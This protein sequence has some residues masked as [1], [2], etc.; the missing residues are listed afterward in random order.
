MSQKSKKSKIHTMPLLFGFFIV[1]VLVVL[2]PLTAPSKSSFSAS[3]AVIVVLAVLAMYIMR[4]INRL[5]RELE[6]EH[7]ARNAILLS[8]TDGVFTLDQD[9]N[10]TSFNESAQEITGWRPEDV[11]K[12]KCYE[13][14]K[15]QDH[16]GRLLCS[17]A[18]CDVLKC[19][20]F[21][22]LVPSEYVMDIAIRDGVS[23]CLKLF[24]SFQSDGDRTVAT[25][26][27]RDISKMRE[28]EILRQDF[29]D[30]MT[31][32][33][34]T[35]I[36]TIKAY[37][38]T[39]RHPKAHFEKE[40][41]DSFLTIIN[42][43]SDRLSRIVDNILEASRITHRIDLNTRAMTLDMVINEAVE[44]VKKTTTIHTFDLTFKSHP[45]VYADSKQ[46]KYVFTHLLTNAVRFSP[47]GGVVTLLLEEDK[48]DVVALSIEDHGI[49]IPFN[50]QKKIFETFHRIDVGTT[51]K[52]YSVGM[53]LY[54]VKRII[55]AHGGIIWV[56]STPG[57]G[58]KF[59]FTLPR[60]HETS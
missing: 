33:L 27:F 18:H 15:G 34:R 29:M 37:V 28:Y 19:L 7:A 13:V 21:G 32:E 26:V 17:E 2:L 57:K 43:E 35:P 36:T 54:I 24:P 60:A 4:Q 47:D 52:I 5:E 55:E 59:T 8:I 25:I 38:A 14:F 46:M 49:G 10:I 16:E 20:R 50:Q 53:G 56:E 3:I 1:I 9:C 51:K 11:L 45:K 58:S 6:K 23:K 31:H 30:S 42:G 12:R 40:A 41:I 44:A 22:G 39:M 48:K